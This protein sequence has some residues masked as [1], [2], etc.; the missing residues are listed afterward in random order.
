MIAPLS[1]P[2]LLRPAT[3]RGEVRLLLRCPGGPG[4][5][6]D[7]WEIPP[8]ALGVGPGELWLEWD[9]S[10]RVPAVLRG[11]G[12]GPDVY[13]ACF[14]ELPWS[15]AGGSYRIGCGARGTPPIRIAA[16]PQRG[17]A[18]RFLLLSDHQQKPGVTATLAA[19]RRL[20]ARSPFHGVLFAGDLVG[21]PDDLSAWCGR[22]D[23]RAFFDSLAA[24][25][26]RVFGEPAVG[27]DAG[28]LSQASPHPLLLSTTPIVPCVGNHEISSTTG[29]TPRDRFI[30][31]APD[32]WNHDTFARL[33]RPAP[34]S[35]Y[36]AQMLGPL[37]IVS[38]FVTRCWLRG[39]HQTRSGPCYER[40]GR[41]IFEAIGPGSRQ[42][43]WLRGE[44][45]A[46]LVRVPSPGR[47]SP[48]L[49]VTLMHHSP[50]AQGHN[51]LPLFGEPVDYREHRIVKHLVP[52]L[53]PWADLVIAGHNHA[54]NHHEVAGIHYLE[55]SHMGVGYPPARVRPDGLAEIEPLGHPSRLFL[56][57][58]GFTFFAVLE[59]RVLPDGR[60]ARVAIY[61]VHPSGAAEIEYSFVL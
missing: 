47:H 21:I 26:D 40:P 8:D 56:S 18:W 37:R 33:F 22:A 17:G 50:F 35:V 48:W 3:D 42:Y 2:W 28:R 15:A 51:S 55:T 31:V 7:R 46:D 43:E 57:E 20:A 10:D 5:L 58:E 16:D 6:S 45:T 41:F 11:T 54:V 1:A 27:P 44:I 25:V 39:D 9:G 53:Q 4:D 14:G 38:L 61:R 59:V 23:G 60:A 49:R 32:D 12:L 30:H 13:V 24:P 36:F 52:Q 19:A 34:Q 29:P